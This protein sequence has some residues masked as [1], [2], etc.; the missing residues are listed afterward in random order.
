VAPFHKKEPI[1]IR[2]VKNTDW[3]KFDEI[4]SGDP[5]FHENN[6]GATTGID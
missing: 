6:L 4:I 3:D 2:L 5:N 1:Q